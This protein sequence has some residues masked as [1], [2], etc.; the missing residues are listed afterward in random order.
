M[1]IRLLVISFLA[2]LM[3]GAYALSMKD[4]IVASK[5]CPD[6]GCV[7]KAEE[8]NTSGAGIVFTGVGGL[9]AAFAISFLALAQPNGAPTGPTLTDDPKD[10]LTAKIE[11][12]I[13]I[14]FVLTWLIFGALAVYFGLYK[15]K[16]IPALAEMGKA[17]FGSVLA[18]VGAYWGIKPK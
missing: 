11:K 9:V 13:P 4:A 18:A 2:I 6:K 15:D 14:L 17:W 12:A 7:S 10:V 16:S 1:N 5:D 3:I 8:F